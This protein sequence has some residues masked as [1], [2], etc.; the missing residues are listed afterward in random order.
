M[1]LNYT[2]D[3]KLLQQAVRDFARREI[4]PHVMVWDEAQ[5]FPADL[6]KEMGRQGYL[7]VVVPE[8]YGGAGM[9]YQDYVIIVTE[10][11]AVCPSVGLGVAAH[12]SLGT[13]HILA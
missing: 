8:A 5:T 2:D 12:N 13:G 9:S 4:L 6:F 3:Q 10:I 7:G 11:S 1:D